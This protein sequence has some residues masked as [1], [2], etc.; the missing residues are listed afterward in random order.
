LQEDVDDLA[1]FRSAVSAEPQARAKPFRFLSVLLRSRIRRLHSRAQQPI[2]LL[3]SR[4]T[5]CRFLSERSLLAVS[6]PHYLC[7][8]CSAKTASLSSGR[9]FRVIL[10]KIASRCRRRIRPGTPIDTESMISQPVSKKFGRSE[11]GKS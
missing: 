9:L 6:L 2:A 1:V 10:C 5:A 7:A 8:G 4:R 11:S 3:D